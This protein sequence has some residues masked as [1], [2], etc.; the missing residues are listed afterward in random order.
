VPA[1]AQHALATALNSRIFPFIRHSQSIATKLS[2]MSTAFQSLQGWL[3][4]LKDDDSVFESVALFLTVLQMF[5]TYGPYPAASGIAVSLFSLIAHG[6]NRF[7]QCQVCHLT[8]PSLFTR[9]QPFWKWCLCLSL[10]IIVSDLTHIC[11][12]YKDIGLWSSMNDTTKCVA[13]HFHIPL[14]LFTN[15]T[16]FSFFAMCHSLSLNVL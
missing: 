9:R 16:S 14:L 4:N 12:V 1:A 13:C 7:A 3:P 15:C 8:S 6:I 2:A 10:V 11:V 5:S